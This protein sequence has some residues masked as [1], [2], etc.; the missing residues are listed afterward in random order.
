MKKIIT[1][2]LFLP[3]ILLLNTAC[4]RGFSD[5]VEKHAL[6]TEEELLSYMN[7]IGYEEGLTFTLID[8][9]KVEEED[10]KYLELTLSA[11]TLPGKEISAIHYIGYSF[12][13][14]EKDT[15]MSII[16]LTDN[17]F[18]DYYAQ[19]YADEL[20]EHFN[21]L[22]EPM[23]KDSD[24]KLLVRHNL[25]GM[26]AE[27][28]YEDFDDFMN[29]NYYNRFHN[30][31]LVE[32]EFTEDFERKYN[33]FCYSLM[34]SSEGTDRECSTTFYFAPEVDSSSVTDEMLVDASS[35][36]EKDKVVVKTHQ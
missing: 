7:N 20:Y 33:A 5:G 30:Y 27:N 24:Y 21:N 26:Y 31:L 13:E 6:K 32:K 28:K 9:K 18:C 19:K 4:P 1:C 36:T 8:S 14:V 10:C 15:R 22:Y 3:L 16:P 11:S 35:F 12:F 17:V 2:I 23:V 25:H 34:N 29:T